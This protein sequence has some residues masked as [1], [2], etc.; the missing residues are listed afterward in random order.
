MELTADTQ[1]QL[2]KLLQMP[3]TITAEHIDFLKDLVARYPYFQPLHLLLAKASHHSPDQQNAFTKASL[4]NGGQ[5]LHQIIFEPREMR[6][7]EDKPVLQG[8]ALEFT[9]C[10]S[11][12]IPQEARAE[13][14]ILAEPQVERMEEDVNSSLSEPENTEIPQ[15]SEEFFAPDI[16]T[17]IEQELEVPPAIELAEDLY[18]SP[19]TEWQAPQVE[20]FNLDTVNWGDAEPNLVDL[21]AEQETELDET[22]LIEVGDTVSSEVEDVVSQ[23]NETTPSEIAETPT[24]TAVSGVDF[25]PEIENLPPLTSELEKIY[26]EAKSSEA[27]APQ[28]EA[29]A[30]NFVNQEPVVSRVEPEEEEIAALPTESSELTEKEEKFFELESFYVADEPSVAVVE[31]PIAVEQSLAEPVKQSGNLAKYD[32]EKMPF[33]FLWWLAKTRKENAQNLQPFVAQQVPQS[34][35]PGMALQQQFAEHIF[36]LEGAIER[37]SAAETQVDDSK[38]SSLHSKE[39][40]I[41]DSFIKNDPQ[42]G[43]PKANQINNENIAKRSAEDHYDLVSETLAEIYTEQTLY[44]KAIDTYRKLSLKFPEKSRY[45]ADLISSLEKKF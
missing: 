28:S 11:E 20:S 5:L 15:T 25:A 30:N 36:H 14:L 31:E 39:K 27:V 40:E 6:M 29:I 12:D 38:T 3:H 10:L 45:F 22:P 41:V 1:K 16:S 35:L 42:M 13:D 37:I 32:D 26:G 18:S 2:Q 17:T 23:S 7:Q 43:A 4:Y 21:E 34:P 44:H 33:S 8:Q 19:H 9:A 24:Y